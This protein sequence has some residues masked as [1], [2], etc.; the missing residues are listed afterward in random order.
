[1][2]AHRD[3][4]DSRP[5]KPRP[6]R[7]SAPALVSPTPKTSALSQRAGE[8]KAALAELNADLVAV[9]KGQRGNMGNKYGNLRSYA[10][11]NE[12]K[13]P[14]DLIALLSE[15]HVERELSQS[16]LDPTEA[17]ILLLRATVLQEMQELGETTRGAGA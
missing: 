16:R 17:R 4:M 10:A 12:T 6:R 15:S 5:P 9:R 14:R 7:A 1:M 8:L 13:L 2:E 3:L 11:S